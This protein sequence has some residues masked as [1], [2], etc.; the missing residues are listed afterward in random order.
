MNT[1]E[2]SDEQCPVIICV[3]VDRLF[4]V[5]LRSFL[6]HG[7]H[8]DFGSR[9]LLLVRLRK[10]RRRRC[11][12]RDGSGFI[13]SRRD[14]FLGFF[15]HLGYL[16]LGLLQNWR[17]H[18]IPSRLSANRYVSFSFSVST[19]FFCL[20]RFA[21]AVDRSKLQFGES[22]PSSPNPDHFETNRIDQNTY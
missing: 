13:W 11:L 3:L 15:L 12:R 17:V 21:I 10:E 2:I 1:R 18:S 9:K 22:I 19:G 8:R 7:L 14:L 5:S 4:L 16:L 20:S 6:L